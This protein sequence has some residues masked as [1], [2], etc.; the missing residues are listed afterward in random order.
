MAASIQRAKMMAMTQEYLIPLFIDM[1]CSSMKFVVP[2]NIQ[3]SPMI[4]SVPFDMVTM[5]GCVILFSTL[6]NISIP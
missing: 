5:T 4:M 3:W 6:Q 2:I 1:R